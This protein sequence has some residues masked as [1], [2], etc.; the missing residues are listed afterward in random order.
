MG[1]ATIRGYRLP[2]I[3]ESKEPFDFLIS[4]GTVTD[5]S[6]VTALG[7]VP[8]AA[9]AERVARLNVVS[10]RRAVDPDTHLPWGT[11][12]PG[13][14]LADELLSI[15]GLDVETTP[16]QRARL[17]REEV[18][19]MLA[20]GVRFEAVLAAGFARMVADA[21]DLADPRV[22]YMLHEIGE[23]TRHS[24]A[25][26]RVIHELGPITRDPFDRP[27][28][29]WA[30]HRLTRCIA[31]HDALL[32]VMTLAGEEIPDLMQKRAAEHPETDP[33]LAALNRYHRQEEARHLSFARTVLPEAWARAG[34]VERTVIRH[35]AP[36]L[37]GMLWQNFVH[38][39]VYAAAGL[40]TWT[41]WNAVQ[42]LPKRVAFREEAT[43][44]VLDAVLDAGAIHRGRVPR[45]WRRLCGVGRHGDPA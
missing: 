11:L 6:G 16:E 25:F 21:P 29:R 33:M 2:K 19:A 3:N 38:P 23:E 17:S 45:G 40:P 42:R 20:M 7:A 8:D 36:V 37:I 27:V 39:G 35:V 12:G 10:G 34:V 5:V 26:L 4:A 22:T 1:M 31:R 14:V 30:I 9:S 15:D 32:L 24:R 13:R 44:P 18:A 43:R 41:T 28:L